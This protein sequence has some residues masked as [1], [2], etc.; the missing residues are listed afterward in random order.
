MI[1]LLKRTSSQESIIHTLNYTGC[2]IF[3][4]IPLKKKK[5]YFSRGLQITVIMALVLFVP[6]VSSLYLPLVMCLS[7]SIHIFTLVSS[8]Q[9]SPNLQL[10]SFQPFSFSSRSCSKMLVFLLDTHHTG[11]FTPISRTEYIKGCTSPILAVMN[12][13]D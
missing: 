1:D 5:N 13:Q 12:Q 6:A 9:L 2:P 4:L 10:R 3:C 11:N 8:V 7:V